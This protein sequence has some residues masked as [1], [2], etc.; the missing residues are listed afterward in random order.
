MATEPALVPI[1]VCADIE[2]EHDHL[3]EVFGFASGGLHRLDDG[4]VVHGE[5]RHGDAVIW[6]HAV[7]PDF[8]LDT[9]SRLAS[10][11]GGLSVRV[12]DVD[13]HFARVKGAGGTIEY[14]PTDQPY[15]L[16]EYGTRDPEGHHWW[17]ATPLP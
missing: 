10:A 17:F 8:E 2:S 12:P 11:H 3:V 6:L 14:E 7:A 13:D 5:V 4:T 1:L 16:R 9:P 15:G